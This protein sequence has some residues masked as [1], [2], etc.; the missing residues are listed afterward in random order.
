MMTGDVAKG[1]TTSDSVVVSTG[2]DAG[3]DTLI[4]L[5]LQ[6]SGFDAQADLGHDDQRLPLAHDR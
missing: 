3:S 1:W 4:L 2:E 6:H 5:H